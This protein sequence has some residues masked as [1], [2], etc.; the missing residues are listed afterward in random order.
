MPVRAKCGMCDET[1]Q[2]KMASFYWRWT[3]PSG[4]RRAYKQFFDAECVNVPLQLLRE[5]QEEATECPICGKLVEAY[6]AITVWATHYIPGQEPATGC[7]EYHESC[8]Q[9]AEPQFLKNAVRLPDRAMVQAGGPPPGHG[10][11]WDSWRQQG[12]DPA[13]KA[14]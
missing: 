5:P 12:I 7:I 3:W 11:P 2:W 14:R 10:N 9:V 6:P 4:D 13:S 1:S 8:F